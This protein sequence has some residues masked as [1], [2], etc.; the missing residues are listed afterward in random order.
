MQVSTDGGM[1]PLWAPDGTELFYRADGKL[2][3]AVVTESGGRLSV[4]PPTVLFDDPFERVSGANPD[5]R[6]YDISP[7][8]TTFAMIRPD[9]TSNEHRPL[10]VVIGWVGTALEKLE[11]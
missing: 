7:D 1:E 11:D 10:R 2:M 8:G 9:P 4:S 3:A 5:Q 6:Q